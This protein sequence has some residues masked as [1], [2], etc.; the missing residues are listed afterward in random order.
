MSWLRLVSDSKVQA[1]FL[2]SSTARGSGTIAV[3]HSARLCRPSSLQPSH[4]TKLYSLTV[5]PRQWDTGG[6]RGRKPVSVTVSG[7]YPHAPK[8]PCSHWR[9]WSSE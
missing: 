1:I 7:T 4:M 9:V 3:A 2:P 8:F 6:E 5:L